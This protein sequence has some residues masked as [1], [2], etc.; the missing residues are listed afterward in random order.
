MTIIGDVGDLELGERQLNG[1]GVPGFG[2]E[3]LLDLSGCDVD[4]L[5][6]DVALITYVR[7]L[8]E[9]IG[10]TTY[11]DPLA[12]CFGEGELAG[13]TVVQLITTSNI[14]LHAAPDTRTVHINVF[15]CR[16]FDPAT[17]TQFSIDYFN[18]A[19]CK[20]Q[21]VERTAPEVST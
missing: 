10:M 5:V 9:R 8:A 1:R 16:A 3:L 20:A 4:V 11:G 15:S 21:T 19:G 14:N 2:M 12:V 18:A 7:M 17:A 13:W 6:S